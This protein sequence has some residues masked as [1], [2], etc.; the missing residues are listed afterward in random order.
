MKK[1]LNSNI[2]YYAVIFTSDLKNNEGYAEMATK[3]SELASQQSGYL[4]HD[5]ACE[6]VGITVSYWKDLDSIQ[7]WKENTEHKIA[8]KIGR[9]KWYKSFSVKI[10]KVEKEYSF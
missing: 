7:K 4:G 9:D 5:S 10:C 1:N 6:E 2:P 8:R 3:M